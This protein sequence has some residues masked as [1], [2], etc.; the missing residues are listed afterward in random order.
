VSDF[1]VLGYEA[2][3]LN[4]PVAVFATKEE[5]PLALKPT[6]ANTIQKVPIKSV[7]S[8]FNLLDVLSSD[9]CKKFITMA[10]DMG[11]VQD[12]SISLPRSVR[13]NDNLV[14]LIDESMHDLLWSRCEAF[15][16]DNALY[17]DKKALALNKR[18]RFYKYNEGDFF[19]PHT[20]GAWPGSSI[21]DNKLVYNA[22]KDRFSQMT[23]LFF[24]NDDYSGG[25]TQFLVDKNDAT[26]PAT[27]EENVKYEDISTPKGGVLC[28]AHGDHPMHCLHSSLKIT[29][30]IKY[31]IRTDVLFEI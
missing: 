7:P 15:L 8:A 13:H 24:L 9:E 3:S 22:Y 26:K 25:A 21:V 28:F 31:I 6:P 12:S 23:F 30:G 20:D 29:Q 10:E 16:Q 11:Y 5:N 17:N 4:T 18:F 27:T 14:W 2:G 1:Y 19:K